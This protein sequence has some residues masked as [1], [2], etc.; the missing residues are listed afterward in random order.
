MCVCVCTR[1]SDLR[2]LLYT[3]EMTFR[4][5]DHCT[6]AFSLAQV[7]L[8]FLRDGVGRHRYVTSVR[9][10]EPFSHTSAILVY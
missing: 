3:P 1:K 6:T 5:G 4:H 9:V 2:Q 10:T 7:A 8:L